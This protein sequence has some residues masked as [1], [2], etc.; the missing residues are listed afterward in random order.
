MMQEITITIYGLGRVG[1]SLAQILLGESHYRY[2][3]NVVD[4]GDH[5]E[6]ALLDLSHAATITG[7]H[8][9]VCNQH[10]LVAHSSY[11][12]HC[13]GPS[14]PPGA[15]RLSVAEESIKLTE[16]IFKG[17]QSMV[18]P[19]LIVIANPLDIIT[20]HTQKVT[21]LPPEKVLGTGTLLDSARLAYYLAEEA[22]VTPNE[23]KAWVL[24]EHG[25]SM[26]PIISQTTINGQPLEAVLS[27]AQIDRCI[28]QTRT[29][30]AII[31]KTLGATSYGVAAC[32]VRLM[33][34]TLD[35]LDTH[36][37]PASVRVDNT[38]REL[39]GGSAGYMGLP[40]RLNADG[41]EV[42][43]LVLTGEEIEALVGSARVLGAVGG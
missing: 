24:G 38:W 19:W 5:V 26:V 11:L 10:D 35:P 27:L 17:F 18:E 43:P 21:G 41:Y 32:A 33:Q 14:V 22:N 31:K 25:D 6:G 4:P 39:L 2:V 20:H 29:S 13:A 7:R 16:Q 8:R 34:A 30:A 12:F 1:Q 36:I 9:L 28:Q 3:I 42:L 37:Y 40:V 23:V 15:S